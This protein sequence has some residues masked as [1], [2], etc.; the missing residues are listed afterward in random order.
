MN[1]LRPFIRLLGNRKRWLL[2]GALLMLCTA[3]ANLGLLALSGWFITATGLTGIALAA[4]VLIQLDIYRPGAGIRFFAVGRAVSRYGE[5]LVNHEAVF[6]VLADLRVWFFRRLL[7]L[8]TAALGRLRNG[9]LLNRITA[10]INALDHLYLRVFGPVAVALL[11][12]LGGLV[13]LGWLAAPMALGA[14]AAIIPAALL[15]VLITRRYSTPA[16]SQSGALT[17]SMREQLVGDLQALAELRIYGAGERRLRQ[18]RNTDRQRRDRQ[19]R[20]ADIQAVSQALIMLGTLGAL[21]AALYIGAGLVAQETIS[22]PVM[23]AVL[24]GLLALSEI[25][26]P[27]PLAFH[28][29]GSV[30]WSAA[31]LLAVADDHDAPD[32]CQDRDLPESGTPPVLAY[33]QVGYRYRIGQ[34][35]CLN[36]L[37]FRLESGERV[38][39][40]GPSGTGKSTLLALALGE[41]QASQGGVTLAG[42]DVRELRQEVLHRQFAWLDQRSTLFAGTVAMNLRLANANADDNALWSVLEAVHL[43]EDIEQRAGGLD[44]WLGEAGS[45][46]SGGQARRLTLARTLLKPAPILLLDEPTE[47]LDRATERRLLADIEPYLR[48]RSLLVIA[49]DPDRLPRVDRCLRLQDGQ[50][51]A[52]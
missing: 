10:D 6:R 25:L 3:A 18:L 16:A 35:S 27:L 33:D 11:G 9:E 49:H 50:L 47:G 42:V 51:R 20:L 43:A 2:A 21:W 13:F 44:A 48:N 52:A 46:L 31:R 1:E 22:G 5:R 4:G 41:I 14:V 26:L 34:P 29:L 19:L 15:A 17:S 36:A 38:A 45:G 37:D 8:N 32:A 40:L 28:M 30:R 24:L 12:G 39:I 7:P 23:V